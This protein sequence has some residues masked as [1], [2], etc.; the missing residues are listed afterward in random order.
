M[1]GL[2][3]DLVHEE[4]ARRLPTDRPARTRAVLFAVLCAACLVIACGYA[5][6]ARLRAD[7]RAQAAFAEP[8]AA[9]SSIG[10]VSSQSHLVFLQTKGDSYR[11]VGLLGLDGADETRSLTLLR[12]QRVHMAAGRGLC[13]GQT[14][15]GGA[16]TFDDTFQPR[17]EISVSGIPSRARVSPDGRYGAMTVFV[18]GHSYAAGG[19]STQTTLIDMATGTMLGAEDED[20]DGGGRPGLESFAVYRDGSRFEA[21]DANFWGVT[22]ARDGDRFYATLGSGGKTYLIEGDIAG[23]QARILAENVECPSLS[24]SGT[25]LAYKKRVGGGGLSPI[26][27][28]LHLLDLA[29]MTDA[30]LA[31]A[32]NVDDQVEW[33]DEQHIL[34]SL[35]DEDPSTSIRPDIWQLALDGSAPRRIASGATSPAVVR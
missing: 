7:A 8:A 33:L 10:M 23:R 16:F 22:F 1:T 9:T 25:R 19:F 35:P 12:C 28:R 27:W 21:E 2:R 24:P 15:R 18:R 6:V 17:H 4:P 34:Y 11:R 14:S 32:R 29:T 13:L 3:A 5:L 30:P 26:V 20:G 31:E